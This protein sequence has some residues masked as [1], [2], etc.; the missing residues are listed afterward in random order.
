MK[1]IEKAKRFLS[2]VYSNSENGFFFSPKGYSTILSDS[3]GIQLAFLLRCQDRFDTGKISEKIIKQQSRETGFFWDQN[4]DREHGSEYYEP[5]YYPWLFTYF[6]T[7]ALDMTGEHLAHPFHFLGPLKNRETIRNW[8]RQRM[9]ERFW[10]ASN[11]IMFLLFFLIYEQ[12]RK[13]ANNTEFINDIFNHLDYYQNQ[14]TGFWGN[15]DLADS[16]F[17]AAH[18]YLF[19][20]YHEREINFQEQIIENTISLQNEFGLFGFKYGGACEDYDA[21]EILCQLQKVIGYQNKK[22]DVSCDKLY[23]AILKNQHLDGGFSYRIDN[24]DVLRRLKKRYINKKEDWRYGDWEKMKAGS[25]FESDLWSTYF[26]MLTLAKIHTM[27]NFSSGS[28][29]Y[30]FYTL[31]G[32]GYF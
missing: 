11:K 8:I 28:S 32:W 15:G 14:N 16:M 4:F 26:R 2:T 20:N 18:I 1:Q 12:T 21:I 9:K 30:Q 7:I 19:Y 31:P 24:R 27:K 13:G 17:G 23:Q 10:H 5:E 22:I 6:A 29:R 3:F 25:F